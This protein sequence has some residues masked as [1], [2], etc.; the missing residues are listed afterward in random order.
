M[1][2]SSMDAYAQWDEE[3]EER[4]DTLYRKFQEHLDAPEKTEYVKVEH[5]GPDVT[6]TPH[7]SHHPTSSETE[8]P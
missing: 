6:Q 3:R 4:E 2:F 8:E 5:T 1:S 7:G